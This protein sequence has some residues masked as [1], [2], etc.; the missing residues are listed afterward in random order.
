MG[1]LIID[2][3]NQDDADND[4]DIN[5]ISEIPG[6]FTNRAK[7]ALTTEVKKE[8][9]RVI[10][11]LRNELKQIDANEEKIAKDAFERE[12][13]LK[14]Y[15]EATESKGDVKMAIFE[16]QKKKEQELKEKAKEIIEQQKSSL[17]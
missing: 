5:V 10:G 1:R 11:E 13:A 12:Q 9:L 14:N 3:F 7:K 15:K 4:I 2:E 8:V 6:D 16:E 17:P